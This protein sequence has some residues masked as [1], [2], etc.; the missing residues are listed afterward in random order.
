MPSPSSLTLII[1]AEHGAPLNEHSEEIPNKETDSL[2]SKNTAKEKDFPPVLRKSGKENQ[3]LRFWST[4]CFNLHKI[5]ILLL[6]LKLKSKH[7]QFSPGSTSFSWSYC[8]WPYSLL[9]SKLS[10]R[11]SWSPSFYH[12]FYFFIIHHASCMYNGHTSNSSNPRIAKVIT[13]A[14]LTFNCDLCNYLSTQGN[15]LKSHKRNHNGETARLKNMILIIPLICHFV[16]TGK[17]F[18]E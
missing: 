18:G 7:L 4:L 17:I 10:C 13:S 15:D 6:K 1:D 11:W 16:Y 9:L 8:W 12:H 3:D 14:V 2:V 5:C